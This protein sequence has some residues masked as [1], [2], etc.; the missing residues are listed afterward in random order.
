VAELDRFGRRQQRHR[1]LEATCPQRFERARLREL[2]E[3][4]GTEL[5]EPG[6]IVA[7]PEAELVRRA[8]QAELPSKGAS[9]KEKIP[10][11]AATNQ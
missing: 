4:A 7:A 8:A 3:V 5:G 2:S 6:G 10:P 1:F 11:S 9:P